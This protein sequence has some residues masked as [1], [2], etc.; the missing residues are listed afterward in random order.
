MYLLRSTLTIDHGVVILCSSVQT[1]TESYQNIKIPAYNE[2][3][4]LCYVYKKKKMHYNK[5]R[6]ENFNNIP[7]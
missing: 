7:K 3:Q 1:D 5:K 4:T 6:K 2:I